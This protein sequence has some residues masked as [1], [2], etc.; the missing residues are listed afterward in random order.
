MVSALAGTIG[1]QWRAVGSLGSV[2]RHLDDSNQYA[3]KSKSCASVR[4]M[5]R[6]EG[7]LHL[8]G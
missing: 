4:S 8:D 7:A 6:D 2:A 1:H 5:R 3:R